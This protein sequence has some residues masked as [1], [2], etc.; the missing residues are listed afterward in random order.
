MFKKIEEY[1]IIS[2]KYNTIEKFVKNDEEANNNDKFVIY[3]MV[4]IASLVLSV[5]N[6]KD[7]YT[8]MLFSTLLLAFGMAITAILVKVFKKYTLADIIAAVLGG[9]IFS[10]YALSGANEGFAILWILILPPIMT[11]INRKVGI[12]FST[13]LLVFT[14]VICYSPMKVGLSA[15]YTRT[16]LER[17]PLLC[18]VDFL[19]TLYVWFQSNLSEK[20]LTIKTYVD[21]LTGVYNRAFYNVVCDYISKNEKDNKNIVLVSMDVNGLKVVNDEKGHLAGDELI[22]GAAS[23]INNVCEKAIIFRTGGDEFVA[24]ILEPTDKMEEYSARFD[25]LQKEWKGERIDSIS[26]S[27]GFASAAEFPNKPLEYVFSVADER[28]YKNKTEYYL[29]NSID[30]RHSQRRVSDRRKKNIL[31]EA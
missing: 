7:N 1:K 24:I 20:Q 31:K 25:K 16:F 11:N 13:Y 6:L 8:T 9:I 19:I 22:K 2:Q 30:R 18:T 29:N 15:V 27:Y 5:L 23:I 10:I 4:S 3:T 14:F 17:F 21:E 26:I 28:M 12:I